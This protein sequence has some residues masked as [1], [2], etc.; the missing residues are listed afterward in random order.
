[1]RCA[2]AAAALAALSLGLAAAAPTSVTVGALSGTTVPP[3]FASLSFWLKNRGL[4]A[5]VGN[6]SSSVPYHDW[7]PQLLGNLRNCGS[8][9]CPGTS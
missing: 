4:F 2:A 9:G 5:F 6:G 8:A 7:F 3:S 1:M